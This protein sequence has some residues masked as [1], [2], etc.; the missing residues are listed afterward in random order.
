MG[1]EW[2]FGVDGDGEEV[3]CGLRSREGRDRKGLAKKEVKKRQIS[4]AL[5]PDPGTRAQPSD[6]TRSN[7]PLHHILAPF[8][9]S[10]PGGIAHGPDHTDRP[11]H[12]KVVLLDGRSQR[13]K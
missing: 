11:R 12:P 5:D 13:V 1:L 3:L 9:W 8:D 4:P 6:S 2:K 7:P 10:P